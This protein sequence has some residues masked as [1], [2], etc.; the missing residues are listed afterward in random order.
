[1]EGANQFFN[2][3]DGQHDGLRTGFSGEMGAGKRDVINP[4]RKD[5]NLAVSDV[6]TQERESCQL[7]SP[8]VEGMSRIGNRELTLE[9]Q[10]V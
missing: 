2:G 8:A 9:G 5:F 3:S 1:L 7:Q 10:R 6:S 4:T